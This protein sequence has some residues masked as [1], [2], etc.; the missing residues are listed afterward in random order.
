MWRRGEYDQNISYEILKEL[1]KIR[2]KRRTSIEIS[3]GV[4]GV[5]SNF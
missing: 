1:I 2:G 4:I 3:K 5:I